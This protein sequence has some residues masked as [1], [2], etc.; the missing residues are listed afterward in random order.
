MK[1]QILLTVCLLLS[2]AGTLAAY[3][4]WTVNARDY[5]YD[6]TVYAQLSVAHQ[7]DYELAAFCGEECRGVGRLLTAADG[8]QVFQLRVWSNE[9]SGETVSFR[10]FRKSSEETFFPETTIAFAAQTVEGM[11]SDPLLIGIYEGLAGDAN[12]D[13]AV[14]IADVTAIINYL[15]DNAPETFDSR[16]AD[17]NGD[18]SVNIADVTGI[19]NMINQ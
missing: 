15:N 13:G 14:N 6:M 7:A 5:R 12:G 17:V 19:I 16:N 11:P 18:K 2:V 3:S 9:T 1:R 4:H 10:V 8:T